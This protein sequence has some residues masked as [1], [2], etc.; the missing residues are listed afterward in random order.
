MLAASYNIDSDDPASNYQV[1]DRL[2]QG[3]FGEVLRAV[4]TPTGTIVALKKILLRRPEK[5]LADNVLREVKL[6][7][8]V[9]H[10]NV[11]R[12]REV[13]AQGSSMVLSC[14]FCTTDLSEIVRLSCAPLP[15]GIVKGLLQQLLRGLAAVHHQRI[16]HR[17]LK[18][19]NVLVSERGVVKIADFGLARCHDNKHP[20]THTVATRWY[21]APELLYGAREYGPAVDMWAVGCIMGEL[22]G[23]GP[24]IP[25]E[26]DIDQLYCVIKLLG[27]PSEEDWPEV[28]TLPDYPKISFPSM[29]GT[30]L[31][32]VLPAAPPSAISLLTRLLS[33][34]PRHRPSA[35]QC[36]QDPLF[37]QEPLPTLPGDLPLPKKIKVKKNCALMMCLS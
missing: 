31:D 18:P 22:L 26:H 13:Y 23:G 15:L 33:L 34:N 24:L 29:P 30:P 12:L 35:T 14:E 7:Q 5:G 9:N 3:S 8:R 16:I 6:L 2:G 1:L 28:K 20:Y 4:H 25:G 32:Q 37:L 10:P 19:S 36:L 27:N 17:D 21:R 11:V